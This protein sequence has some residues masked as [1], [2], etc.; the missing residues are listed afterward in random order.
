MPPAEGL[1]FLNEN[2]GF[3]LMSKIWLRSYTDLKGYS[4]VSIKQAEL[5]K[6]ALTKQSKI[7]V[8]QWKNLGS[9]PQNS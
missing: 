2:F 5:S 9:F 3:N 6:Q 7:N 8:V 4:Q 1:I